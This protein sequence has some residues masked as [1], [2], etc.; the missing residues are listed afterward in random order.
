MWSV[1]RVLM[2]GER[3]QLKHIKGHQAPPERPLKDIVDDMQAQ[4]AVLESSQAR[5]DIHATVAKL[6]NELSWSA[7]IL[8]FCLAELMTLLYRYLRED[9]EAVDSAIIPLLADYVFRYRDG[10]K[11]VAKIDKWMGE[12]TY[13]YTDLDRPVVKMPRL[14]KEEQE[15]FGSQD[16]ENAD[17]SQ[18]VQTH[19][20]ED[21]ISHAEAEDDDDDETEG[22]ESA[23]QESENSED[24]DDGDRDETESANNE[25]AA[26]SVSV[27]AAGSEGIDETGSIDAQDAMDES[28]PA[29]ENHHVGVNCD[30]CGQEDIAGTR[31]KCKQCADCKLRFDVKVT[32]LRSLT[33]IGLLR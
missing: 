3:G 25:N 31:Y 9:K 6:F 29:L 12:G 2:G 18:S 10:A 33:L 5:P 27:E 32:G 14:T 20:T 11:E 21:V 1:R 8:S 13:R 24:N 16:N 17:C 15:M 28:A 7:R 4:I 26:S 22:L 19:E 30:G 23:E